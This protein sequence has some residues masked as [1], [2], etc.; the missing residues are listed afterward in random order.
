M[1]QG[2]WSLLICPLETF[3]NKP[4]QMVPRDL[5]IGFQGFDSGPNL[6]PRFF[7]M[8]T[9]LN[10]WMFSLRIQ[11]NPFWRQ[12]FRR[13]QSYDIGIGMERWPTKS[14]LI[15]MVQRILWFFHIWT[16]SFSH[17]HGS[18]KWPFWRFACSCLDK[19]HMFP[20]LVVNFM[21]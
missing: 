15:G 20:K 14:Y 7:L 6:Q 9:I 2:F 8:L 3:G 4:P 21:V 19:N 12:I 16:Y 11:E 10:G 13:I 18:G 1:S 5:N 17:N